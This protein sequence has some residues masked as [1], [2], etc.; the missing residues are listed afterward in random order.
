MRA[1][2]APPRLLLAADS[3]RDASRAPRE[4]VIEV[5]ARY[6]E[7]ESLAVALAKALD[8]GAEGLLAT[9]WPL[10]RSA[11]RE[12]RKSVPLFALLPGISEYER[13]E[14]D[15][16]VDELLRRARRVAGPLARLRAGGHALL[17]P[18]AARRE[19]ALVR[20][21]QLIELQLAAFRPRTLHGV[22]LNAT[23]TDLALA[24]GH[25]RFFD[26][27][28]RWVRSRYRAAA[29]LETRNPGTL[30]ARLAGWGV[31]P[32]FVLAPFNPSGLGVKPSLDETLAAVRDT[33]IP[34]VARELRAGNVHLLADAAAWAFAHGAAGVA[35]DV[36]EVGDLGAELRKIAEREPAAPPA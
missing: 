17:H 27:Y 13:D 29:A 21:P 24:G 11:V 3:L 19:D 14:L 8:A 7:T 35:P 30:L 20:V 10:L 1:P 5:T 33:G 25:A 4:R 15:P 26:V 12:L 22:V 31:R 23:V 6:R 34:L 16:G 28:V 18:L 9:P 36:A 2:A 32:D